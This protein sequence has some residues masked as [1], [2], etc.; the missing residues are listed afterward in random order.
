MGIKAR[1][2]VAAAVVAIAAAVAVMFGGTL[3]WQSISQKAK[4]EKDFYSN[5]GGRLHDDFNGENKD[6]YVENFTD[7]DD[8]GVPIY[9]RIR[10]Y[11]YMETGTGAGN[12]LA[13]NRDVTVIGKADANINDPS[14]WAIH[15]P[16][17]MSQEDTQMHKYWKWEM[18]GKT[19]YMPTFNKDKDSLEADINGTL[20]GPDG[21]KGPDAVSGI[22]DQFEDYIEYKLN[23][24]KTDDAV[25]SA[26]KIENETHYAKETNTAQVLTMS[27]WKA[28]GAPKGNY[29]VYDTDGW[30]YWADAIQP[31]ETT[32]LLLS[33]IK[34]E[35]QPDLEGY[36]AVNVV[37]QF[38]TAGDWGEKNPDAAAQAFMKTVLQTMGFLY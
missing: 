19:I 24:E 16:G 26:D 29:W 34:L 31:G 25:Y 22:Y 27:D 6:V 7:P 36:Y 10:L 23:D 3:A 11:E 18:G 15:I 13:A 35:R 14:T 12:P 37:G 4:N 1:K 17:D 9:A 5:P 32:G 28:M 20:E 30:A 38:A 21:K 2:K 8:K 33:S